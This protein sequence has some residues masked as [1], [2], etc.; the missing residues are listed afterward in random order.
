MLQDF[1]STLYKPINIEMHTRSIGKAGAASI[2]NSPKNGK[3]FTISKKVMDKINSPKAVKISIGK[4]RIA[5]LAEEEDS[6][7]LRLGRIGAKGVIYSAELVKILTE[8]FDLDFSSRIC[9]TFDKVK[10]TVDGDQIVAE[11]TMR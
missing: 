8:K 1:D 6:E 9:I 11:I 10:Y 3:R 2:I 7:A 4:N 5:I